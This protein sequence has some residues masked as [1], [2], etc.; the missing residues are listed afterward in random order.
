MPRMKKILLFLL[1]LIGILILANIF[2]FS[3]TPFLPCHFEKNS[4]LTNPL[5]RYIRFKE[6]YPFKDKVLELIESQKQ[7]GHV[8][9]VAVYFR[10]LADGLWFGINEKELFT[11]A[12]LLKVPV[13]ITYLKEAESN[14]DILNKKLIFEQLPS[15][16]DPVIEEETKMEAGRP[17]KISELIGLMIR[18]SDNRAAQILLKNINPE[19]FG[20]TIREL[21]IIP[22]NAP[23]NE[24]FISLKSYVSVLRILYNATY[25]NEK[26][27]RL[28]L[29]YLADTSF[30]KGIAAE[31]PQGVV[32]VH[33]FGIRTLPQLQT[34]QFH[35]IGIIYHPNNPYLLGIMTKGADVDQLRQVLREIS[36][37]IYR[38]VDKQYKNKD[39]T[40]KM[41]EE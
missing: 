24:N 2:L 30:K 18:H 1:V 3:Q 4:D 33:K 6:L 40:F 5:R 28:A 38:E 31:I 22:E 13:M 34:A 9:D 23:D 8:K 7:S 19:V 12:S 14:P 27:S 36:G 16:L 17:Y 15:S 25:L 39:T 10:S 11:P 29:W 26:M 32:V 20:R 21:G 41:S 37:F 35:D